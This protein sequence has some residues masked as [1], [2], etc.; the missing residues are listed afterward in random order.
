LKTAK[1]PDEQGKIKTKFEEF[2]KKI[3][4][5]KVTL[6]QKAEA[7]QKTKVAAATQ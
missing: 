3:E 6:N 1:N 4:S 2:L 7:Y 5:E